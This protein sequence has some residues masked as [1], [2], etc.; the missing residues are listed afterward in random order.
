MGVKTMRMGTT[1]LLEIQYVG[2]KDMY[3]SM[4]LNL[5]TT[6]MQLCTEAVLWVDE[7]REERKVLHI[8]TLRRGEAPGIISPFPEQA[9]ASLR[10]A[11][12]TT[13]LQ[14]AIEV[15]PSANALPLPHRVCCAMMDRECR[16]ICC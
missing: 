10:E 6:N 1:N 9:L 16:S 3:A 14:L 4:A 11:L 7:M 12:G 8:K 2:P 13:N 5:S 15:S